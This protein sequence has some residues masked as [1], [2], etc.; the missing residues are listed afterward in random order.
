MSFY[1]NVTFKTPSKISAGKY[2][3][4]SCDDLYNIKEATDE[5]ENNVELAKNKLDNIMKG[6]ALNRTDI[7]YGF[8]GS[9]KS[10]WELWYQRY[11]DK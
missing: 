2:E 9:P 7:S 8:N 3:G 1:A 6:W 11:Y 10:G 4:K 5:L